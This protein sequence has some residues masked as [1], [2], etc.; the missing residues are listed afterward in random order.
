MEGFYLVWFGLVWSDRLLTKSLQV[1]VCFSPSHR[2]G[3]AQVSFPLT[4]ED[5]L[6]SA[7]QTP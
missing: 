3:P 6:P 7:K 2:A 5:D 4:E 1:G